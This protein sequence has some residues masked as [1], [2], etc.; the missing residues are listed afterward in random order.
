[1]TP[2]Q[3]DC[4]L[5]NLAALVDSIDELNSDL[6]YRLDKLIVLQGGEPRYNKPEDIA[7]EWD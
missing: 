4:L 2:E 5:G 3:I 1:M 6:S 7:Q